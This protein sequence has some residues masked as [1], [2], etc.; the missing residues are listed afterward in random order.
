[1]MPT[2]RKAA[3]DIRKLRTIMIERPKRMEKVNFN[4]GFMPMA[5]Q[6]QNIPMIRCVFLRQ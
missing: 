3:L 6:K 4:P 5:L 2:K 1:M